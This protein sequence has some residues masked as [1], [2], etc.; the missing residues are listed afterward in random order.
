MNA[1]KV[2]TQ[3]SDFKI[4]QIITES[5]SLVNRPKKRLFNNY[6]INTKTTDQNI[7]KPQKQ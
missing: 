7:K 2:Q 5:K 6:Q 4:F 3:K 1:L